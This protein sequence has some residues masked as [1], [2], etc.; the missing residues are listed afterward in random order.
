MTKRKPNMTGQ[1]LWNWMIESNGTG[2]PNTGCILWTGRMLP[3]GYGVTRHLGKWETTHRLSF[4]IHKG[5]P[6]G[7]HVR[8]IC[9]H[10]LCM[11]PDHLV[12]G[13]HDENMQDKVTRN[14]TFKPKGERH[15]GSKLRAE[16]VLSIR[17]DSRSYPA[18]AADYGIS[19]PTVCNIKKRNSWSHLPEQSNA[20]MAGRVG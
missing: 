9:D 7:L 17:S 19:A 5:H 16:D 12:S 13:T 1:D 20:R 3:N 2:E 4:I 6:Q 11:N 10:K 14:R 15:P 18:I 8:H